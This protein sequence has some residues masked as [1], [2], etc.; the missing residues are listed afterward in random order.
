M[1]GGSLSAIALGLLVN[2]RSIIYSAT[3]APVFS[4]QPAVC[5][6]FFM[7]VCQT[8]NRLSGR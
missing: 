1:G 6:T 5:H 7:S 4:R 2:A 3:L 8:K